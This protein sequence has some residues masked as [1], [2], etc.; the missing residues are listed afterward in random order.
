MDAS[1]ILRIFLAVGILATGHL[2][3]LWETSQ[4]GKTWRNPPVALSSGRARELM[5]GL[6]FLVGTAL[7]LTYHMT[8]ANIRAAAAS[9]VA[10]PFAS[11]AKQGKCIVCSR[12]MHKWDTHSS[13][14]ECATAAGFQCGP[15]RPCLRCKEWDNTTWALY[16]LKV[17]E[18]QSTKARPSARR[19]LS[20][21]GTP[22]T[23]S[24]IR[25]LPAGTFTPPPG[26]PWAA[27]MAGPWGPYRM[28]TPQEQAEFYRGQLELL[29]LQQP[30]TQRD[31]DLTCG[32][33]SR[34][35]T[36]SR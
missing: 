24:S 3:Y 21:Q 22:A 25:S 6:L 35:G 7:S 30:S 19:A 34:S 32:Q 5:F 31:E 36:L 13:C 9:A 26:F 14:I 18:S 11:Q 8:E 27:A 2:D 15:D 33:R 10:D 1:W 20:L 28:P 23:P 4:V 12:Y 17:R 16:M 29:Q